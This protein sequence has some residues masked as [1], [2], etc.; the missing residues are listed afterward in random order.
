MHAAF[1]MRKYRSAIRHQRHKII[2]HTPTRQERGPKL[3]PSP[4]REC[5]NLIFEP[6]KKYVCNVHV[7]SMASMASINQRKKPHKPDRTSSLAEF[8]KGWYLR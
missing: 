8:M 1:A 3:P 7:A 2:T 4:A 6:Q 5:R